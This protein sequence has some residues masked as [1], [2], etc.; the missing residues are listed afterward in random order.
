MKPS[1]RFPILAALA[2]AW[3][4]LSSDAADAARDQEEQRLIAVMGSTAPAGERE[5]ACVRLH[6]IGSDRAVSALAALLGD[7]ELSHAARHALESMPGATAGRALINAL[8]ATSGGPRLGVITSLG[9]RRETAAVPALAA[10]LRDADVAAAEASAAALGAISDSGALAAL[11]AAWPDSTGVGRAAITD[12]LLAQAWRLLGAGETREAGRV[13]RSVHAAE[14]DS[15]VRMAADE[16]MIRSAGTVGLSLVRAGL[17]GTVEPERAAAMRVISDL[18]QPGLGNLLAEFL[19]TLPP[20]VQRSVI[21]GWLERADPP[22]RG[23]ILPLLGSDSEEVRVAAVRALGRVGTSADLSVLLTLA[24]A[25]GQSRRAARLALASLNAP[26]FGAALLGLAAG[27]EGRLAERI[28]AVRALGDRGE[29]SAV[30]GL[31]PLAR[32]ADDSLRQAALRALAALV[33]EKG[34][35]ELVVVLEESVTEAR[36]G[37]AARALALALGRLSPPAGSPA[38]VA[39]DRLW[40]RGSGQVRAALL[41]ATSGLVA[42]EVRA[43]LRQGLKDDAPAVRTAALNALAVTNDPAVLADARDLALR[44]EDEPAR[45]AGTR[46]LV[47]L[48]TREGSAVSAGERIAFYRALAQ[49]KPTL[50]QRRA[51]LGGLAAGRTREELALA[52][53]WLDDADSAQDAA[54]AVVRLAPRVGEA[55]LALA[56]LTRVQAMETA[57]VTKED[58][59]AALESVRNRADHVTSWLASPP[60]ALSGVPVEGLLDAPL[61]PDAPLAEYRDPV[62]LARMASW[63]P[64]RVALD[65]RNSRQLRG[66]GPGTYGAFHAH[67][68]V[69]APEAVRARLELEH[70]C[71]LRLRIGDAEVLRRTDP[72]DGGKASARAEADLVAGWNLV[73]LKVAQPA[74]SWWFSLR[75]TPAKEGTALKMVADA[76][77]DD[78]NAP[79]SR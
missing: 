20:F 67:T 44:T 68:W 56:A 69:W 73:L 35:A 63:E 66:G 22:P 38:L 49:S 18:P 79:P 65:Q 71:A 74:Q 15:R 13:F 28:E 75:V 3:L 54:A 23:S 39:V 9:V 76:R 24:A 7:S 36:R 50:A 14:R 8:A 72:A 57:A 12:S 1:S 59:T 70:D 11:E 26:G 37:E 19:P 47:R 2:W 42:A 62:R 4:P 48:T 31:I 10:L 77:P 5:A 27:D 34:S 45:E 32:L 6:R 29:R 25:D 33:D 60:A 16:G 61:T 51:L 58:L 46:A 21:E 52:I 30:A 78:L 55:P 40:Q 43:W 64:M 53:G 41:G 17:T